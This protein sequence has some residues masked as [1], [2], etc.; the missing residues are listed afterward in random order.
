MLLSAGGL[1]TARR[2]DAER[3]GR[4]LPAVLWLILCVT[5]FIMLLAIGSGYTDTVP[6]YRGGPP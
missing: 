2:W 3:K 4:E 6:C 5:L 1:W